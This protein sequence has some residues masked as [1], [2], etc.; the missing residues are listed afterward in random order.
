MFVCLLHLNYDR[1]IFIIKRQKTNHFFIYL[2]HFRFNFVVSE[3]NVHI[4][5]CRYFWVELY[6]FFWTFPSGTFFQVG[7]G[8]GG[9]GEGA[10]SPQN[11]EGP[12]FRETS[13]AKRMSAV[14]VRLN[15]ANI[16][17]ASSCKYGGKRLPRTFRFA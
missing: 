13:P 5:F 2:Q 7:G 4:L 12:G 17:P 6:L 10:R 9:G 14:A 3:R 16:S 11:T 1:F 15:F 8:G